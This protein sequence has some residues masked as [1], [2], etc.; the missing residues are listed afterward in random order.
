MDTDVSAWLLDFFV[1]QPIHDSTLTTLL[2]SL[3]LS[4]TDSTFKKLLLLRKIESQISAPTPHLLSL[5]ENIEE[6][7]HR[8]NVITI[9]SMKRAYC[10]VAVHC[11]FENGCFEQAVKDIWSVRVGGMVKF[12]DVGLLCDELITWKDDFE[13]ALGDAD[14]KKGLEE[15]W[16]VEVAVGDLLRAFV[17]EAKEMIPPSF[18]ELVAQTMTQD[19]G[20]PLRQLFGMEDTQHDVQRETVHHRSEVHAAPGTS[21][22][23][24][25]VDNDD[26]SDA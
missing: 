22:G 8:E 24:E 13:K 2:K 26:L 3:P 5:L 21:R 15:K 19:D 14:V 1:R 23:V 25:I 12:G 9:E 7:D 4:H 17:K 18:L 6:L 16:K 20:A 11:T 10:A